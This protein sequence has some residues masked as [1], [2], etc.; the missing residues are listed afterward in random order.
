MAQMLRV[1][2]GALKV[3]TNTDDKHLIIEIKKHIIKTAA[4]LTAG[5]NS[6]WQ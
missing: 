6:S 4:E 2:A 1:R 5:L 3:A